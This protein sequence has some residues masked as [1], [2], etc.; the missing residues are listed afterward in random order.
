MK[1]SNI[2]IR[3]NGVKL[4]KSRSWRIQENIDELCDGLTNSCADE[5][6]GEIWHDKVKTR[7]RGQL[8]VI[9]LDRTQYVPT[10]FT[11]RNSKNW[12]NKCCRAESHLSHNKIQILNILNEMFCKQMWNNNIERIDNTNV[13]SFLPRIDCSMCRNI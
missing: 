4:M 13:T 7:N 2:D 5:H 12:F 3:S 6:R 8:M 9:N 11:H 1:I 10:H